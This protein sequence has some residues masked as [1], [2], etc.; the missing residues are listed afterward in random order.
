[1]LTVAQFQATDTPSFTH[2]KI[3]KCQILHM[4][5]GALSPMTLLT[6]IYGAGC[7]K[8]GHFLNPSMYSYAYYKNLTSGLNMVLRVFLGLN[9]TERGWEA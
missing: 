1:M 5:E 2:L 6:P 3:S 4:D 8:R 9:V 7:K